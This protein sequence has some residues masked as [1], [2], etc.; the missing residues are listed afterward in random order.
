MSAYR[1]GSH[2]AKDKEQDSCQFI[3]AFSGWFAPP[4]AAAIAFW[5]QHTLI[6]LLP[7]AH[8]HHA[9]IQPGSFGKKRTE[10]VGIRLALFL[11]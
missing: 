9:T 5:K 3:S 4:P 8:L 7:V 1:D 6:F 11:S 10:I 2:N